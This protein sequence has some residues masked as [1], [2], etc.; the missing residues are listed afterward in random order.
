MKTKLKIILIGWCLLLISWC[1]INTQD[2]NAKQN[3]VSIAN[4]ASVYCEENWW[5]IELIFDNGESY[6]ICNFDNWNHCE[7]WEYYRGE[8][9]PTQKTTWDWNNN[10]VCLPDTKECPDWSFVTRTWLECNFETCATTSK[11]QENLNNK[12]SISEIFNKHK[13][14]NSQDTTWLTQEDITLMEEIVEKLK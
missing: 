4:P 2:Q 10:L 6:G 7:E 12:I 3:N 14:S 11:T 8:C 1:T 13:S 5:T 9:S